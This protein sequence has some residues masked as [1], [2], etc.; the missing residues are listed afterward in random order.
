M[1]QSHEFYFCK[2]N[3]PKK[4]KIS[5]KKIYQRCGSLNSE[6]AMRKHKAPERS[7]W[8]GTPY[9]Y[10]HMLIAEQKT[11]GAYLTLK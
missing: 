7:V 3:L 10:S 8:R 6:P 1:N 4:I 2:L 9:A 5:S 11:W